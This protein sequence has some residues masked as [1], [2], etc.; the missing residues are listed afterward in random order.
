MA[1]QDAYCLKSYIFQFLAVVA[2]FVVAVVFVAAAVAAAVAVV[3]V[4]A[5]AVVVVVACSLG[6]FGLAPDCQATEV[7]LD[8]ELLRDCVWTRSWGD[9]EIW[10]EIAKYM[11]I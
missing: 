2:V 8:A 5:V 3:F 9:E 10:S 6:L 1:N 4:F 7:L 11:F